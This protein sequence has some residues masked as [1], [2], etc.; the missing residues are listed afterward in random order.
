MA[1]NYEATEWRIRGHDIKIQKRF[2]SN[3]SLSRYVIIDPFDRFLTKNLQ[4]SHNPLASNRTEAFI[5]STRFR[6]FDDALKHV[7]KYLEGVK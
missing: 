6:T 5:N 2:K 7:E 1:I 3:D 4:W